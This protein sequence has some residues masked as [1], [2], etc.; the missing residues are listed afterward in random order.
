M[1]VSYIDRQ[2]LAAIAPAV[3]SALGI[4]H[5]HFGWLISAFSMAYLVG[6]PVAGIMVDRLG[7]RRGFALAVVAWSLV[8]GAHAFATGFA[9]LFGLR[10]LLGSAESPSFPSAAQAIRRAL[11]EAHRPLAFGLLFTGSS[12]GAV[13]AAKLAVGLEARYGFRYAFIGTAV[14][15]TVWIPFWLLASRGFGLD[16]GAAH[17]ATKENALPRAPVWE[18][19][20]SPPVLRALIAIFGSAPA[21]MFALNWTSQYLVEGWHFKKEDVGNHLAVAPIAFDAAAIAFGW[22]GMRR[23]SDGTPAMRTHR[24]LILLSMVLAAALAFAPLA[25][26][27]DVAI[28]IFAVSSCGGAGIYVL[29]TADV[30]GRV[31]IDRASTAGG[32]CAAAQSLSHIIASPLVGSVIDRTHGFSEVLIGLGIIVIPT[33]LAFAFWPVGSEATHA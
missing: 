2:T 21:L 9:I 4:D 16:K 23:V 18:V 32:M 15:G 11:P 25:P 19:A 5:T 27:A 7:A 31:P 8:A 33:S 14:I 6:A 1:S 3:K 10:I 13:V 24:D 29:V 28:A 12:I 20:S 22:L 30:L 17:P 26:N